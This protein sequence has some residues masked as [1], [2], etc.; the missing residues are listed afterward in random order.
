MGFLEILNIW[1]LL[2]TGIGSISLILHF[3]FEYK[4]WFDHPLLQFVMFVLLLS[5]YIWKL[6]TLLVLSIAIVT[7]VYF[8][9]NLW[10]LVTK[11]EGKHFI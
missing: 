11:T 9:I 7:T 8:A 4:N 6:P 3:I 2:I 5:T 1:I 10:R